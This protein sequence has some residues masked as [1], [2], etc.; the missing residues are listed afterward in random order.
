MVSFVSLKNSRRSK[1]NA[2][3]LRYEYEEKI[4]RSYLAASALAP[5]FRLPS[6]AL[7]LNA[8]FDCCRPALGIVALDTLP[9]LLGAPFTIVVAMLVSP[10]F[11]SPTTGPSCRCGC[12]LYVTEDTARVFFTY[13]FLRLYGG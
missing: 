1:D 8:D 13:D 3:S 7:L 2:Q 10:F 4:C 5:G 12:G 11:P 6:V 9:S